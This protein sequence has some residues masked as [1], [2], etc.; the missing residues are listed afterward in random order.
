MGDEAVVEEKKAEFTQAVSLIN[1][2][3]EL[4]AEQT[5]EDDLKISRNLEVIFMQNNR[6]EIK[7]PQPEETETE[8]KAEGDEREGAE[9]GADEGA[10]EEGAEGSEKKEGKFK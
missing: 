3:F 10:E 7:P 9:K 1:N 6:R 8:E 5:A 2:L 4:P